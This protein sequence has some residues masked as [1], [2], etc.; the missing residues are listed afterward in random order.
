MIYKHSQP[1]FNRYN[2]RYIYISP[3][4]QITMQYNKVFTLIFLA[5]ATIFLSGIGSAYSSYYNDYSQNLYYE[6]S[7]YGYD[8]HTYV[9]REMHKDPWGEKTTYVK[10]KDYDGNYMRGYNQDNYNNALSDY[11][12]YGYSRPTYINY[13]SDMRY[14]GYGPA[15]YYNSGCVNTRYCRW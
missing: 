4:I 6:K 14:N 9:M 7:T 10:V 8:G 12:Y 15:N 11:W 3:S 1:S 13:A 5:L 2:K